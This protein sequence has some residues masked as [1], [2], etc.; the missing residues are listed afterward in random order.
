MLPK[1]INTEENLH[2]LINLALHKKN[3]AVDTEFVWERT[4]YPKLG[5]VQ[6]GFSKNECFLIDAVVLKDIS[7]LGK[8]IS[9][10]NVTKILHD[11]HQ[12]L[13]ILRKATGSFP[14]NI[15][16]TQYAAGFIGESISI[17]LRQ[18]VHQLI[19]VNL[20]KTETRT[21][22]MRRPL[23]RRQVDY[24]LNDVRYL[25]SVMQKT[26]SRVS[27]NGIKEWLL[28]DLGEL[29][30][31]D[32]YRERDTFIQIRRIKGTK[33][34][35]PREMA[36]LFELVDWRE[37]EARAQDRPREHIVTDRTLT[38]ITRNKPKN[39]SELRPT[40]DFPERK[41]REYGNEMV[42]AVNR[43]LSIPPLRYHR[44]RKRIMDDN[45]LNAR[46]DFAMAYINGMCTN[47]RI[48]PAT[49]GTRA[50]ITEF[51]RDCSSKSYET[52]KLLR[53]WRNTFIG[54]KL[55]KLLAGQ[56][57][58]WLDPSTGLPQITPPP[59]KR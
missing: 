41:A 7:P 37:R 57:A 45:T 55:K 16:D 1:I 51:V 48:N 12:D 33:R 38:S 30:N 49:I 23:S 10:S 21:N 6:I 18:L 42:N 3:V 29:D 43:G 27:N 59:V 19:G 32:L 52:H 17:S 39:I 15:F 34:F 28:E 24:A 36:V 47:R 14:K 20:S 13:A 2:T 35:T 58:I 9:D 8:L 4:Y 44:H 54:D 31:P 5:I 50:E 53:G 22:W 46:V 26:V 40:K 56:H 25:P 11:A